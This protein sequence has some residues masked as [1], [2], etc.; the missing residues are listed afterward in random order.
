[1]HERDP[2]LYPS[3]I[4]DS[5]AAIQ[6]FV[7]GLSFEKFCNDRKTYSALIREFEI[8]GEAVGKLTDELKRE[9]YIPQERFKLPRLF[10][11]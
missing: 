3:D 2:R 10:T 7:K 1:M 5:C 8:V 4:S 11:L 9:Y 6:E